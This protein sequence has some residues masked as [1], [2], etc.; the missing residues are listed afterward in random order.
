M[1]SL[2]AAGEDIGCTVEDPKTYA[3][4]RKTRLLAG[5]GVACVHPDPD[6]AACAKGVMN[7]AGNVKC[8][9]CKRTLSPEGFVEHC[10]NDSG[11]PAP[12]CLW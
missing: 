5:R 10:G 4:M 6:R 2:Q 11:Q 7:A 9:G 12:K 3:A 1:E 8:G